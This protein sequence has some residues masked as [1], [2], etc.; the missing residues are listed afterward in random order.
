MKR[1]LMMI[2]FSLLAGAFG[3]Y[4]TCLARFRIVG[5]LLV[6][7]GKAEARID[8]GIKA[9]EAKIEADAAKVKADVDSALGRTA[10]Q[11]A[12]AVAPAQPAQSAQ[13]VQP[14]AGH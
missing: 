10:V 7:A 2:G 1:D 14:L 8:S 4:C 12:E 11:V 6:L 5:A 3:G 9:E 13:P